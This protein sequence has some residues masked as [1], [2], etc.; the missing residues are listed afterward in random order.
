MGAKHPERRHSTISNEDLRFTAL[1]KPD[2]EI[3]EIDRQALDFWGLTPDQIRGKRVWDIGWRLVQDEQAERLKA[4]VQ[5][6]ALGQVLRREAAVWD[7]DRH[8][9]RL[10]FSLRPLRDSRGEIVLLVADARRLLRRGTADAGAGAEA[11]E[12][13]RM[14]SRQLL[15]RLDE[16]LLLV[17]RHGRIAHLNPGAT[18]VLNRD[19]RALL[20]RL[21]ADVL[22]LS[23]GPEAWEA[24]ETAVHVGCV[25]GVQVMARASRI[26]PDGWLLVLRDNAATEDGP[27]DPLTGLP[28]RTALYNALRGGLRDSRAGASHVLCYFDLDDFTRVNDTLGLSGGDTVLR[29]VA[30]ELH[31]HARHGDV[32]ARMGEDAFALLLRDCGLPDAQGVVESLLQALHDGGPLA[33]TPSSRLSASAGL[34]ALEGVPD[35]GTVLRLAKQACLEAKEMGGNR[36]AVSRSAASEAGA[37]AR[38]VKQALSRKRLRLYQQPLVPLDGADGPRAEVLLRLVTEDGLDGPATLLARADQADLLGEIDRWVI[39]QVCAELGRGNGEYE[40]APSRYSINLS[41]DGLRDEQLPA[42]V[43]NRLAAHGAEPARLAFELA[44]ADVLADLG[45]ATALMRALRELG[46]EVV[47]DECGRGAASLAYL[48]ELPV[49]Q[50]KIARGL[51]AELLVD[52]VG[53]VLIQAIAEIAHLSG[54]TCVAKG[55]ENDAQ[56]A[57]LQELPVDF[58]QGFGLAEPMRLGA[59]RG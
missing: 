21:A 12:A 34:C 42:Y 14:P 7:T 44:E 31:S 57:R 56:A 15:D 6:A 18:L 9:M 28:G 40:L 29:G 35:A 10:A 17:D 43:R 58:G 13:E 37:A 20:N 59:L 55:V 53:A 16:A 23:P 46:C 30:Q 1:L 54:K 45:T 5:G 22:Q 19:P 47:L 39:D 52:P 3:L 24:E 27:R 49:N 36:W 25:A 2:G 32:L 38:L 51:V 11:A 26:D 33:G 8:Q 50:V 41:R 4:A 48:R